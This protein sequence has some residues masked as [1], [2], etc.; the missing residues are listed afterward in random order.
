MDTQRTVTRYPWVVAT[1]AVGVVGLILAFALP[2]YVLFQLGGVEVTLVQALVSTFALIVAA[3][4]FRDMVEDLR[5]GAWGIDILAIVAICATVLVGEYWAALVVCLMLSGGEALEDFASA[6]ARSELTGVL[7]RAP[8]LAHRVD[9]DTVTTIPVTEVRVGD[10]LLIRPSEILPVDAELMTER[11]ALDESS[12]TGESLPVTHT[13]GDEVMSGSLNG[14]SAI[15]VRA[16]S[17][18]ANSRYQ[19]IVSLVAEA[20][21]SRSPMVRLADRIALPFTLFSLA[22]AGLGWYLAGDPLRAAQILVVATPCPLLIAAPVAFMAGMSR[23]ARAGIIVKDG[24]TIE[25]LSR[26]ETAAFDK[27]GTL[28]RGA[29]EVVDITVANGFSADEILQHAAAVEEYSTHPLARAIVAAAQTK[30]LSVPAASDV[31]EAVA[32]GFEGIVNGRKVAVGKQSWIADIVTDPS[33]IEGMRRGQKAGTSLVHVAIDGRYVGVIALADQ[34]RPEAA[35]TIAELG[36]LGVGRVMMLSG[37]TPATAKLVGKELGI[38]DVRAGLLP[39]DKVGAIND[40]S[41]KPV[42]MVGDGVNDAPVL[43]AAD[44]GVAMGLTGSAAAADSADVVLMKDDVHR[45][46]V[47]VGVGQHTTRVAL[48]AIGIGVALSVILM[49]IAFTGV[50]PAIVG[51]GA[52]ELVDLVCILWA[53]RAMKPGRHEPALTENLDVRKEC[54]ATCTLPARDAKECCLATP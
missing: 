54:F 42:M 23:A 45:A 34:Y 7:E 24:G 32:A 39:E 33:A 37:D 47:A 1:L 31:T 49:G 53:L 12:L 44:V 11:A 36:R 3:D 38:D 6:R 28:T 30:G 5:R 29:P 52:Q 13:R 22:V 27:T 8:S 2:R 48:Q 15:H 4:Q 46:A 51:A 21:E 14:S 17:D 10:I 40:A 9:G 20:A 43:A 25:R 26:I 19:Q 16:L 18:A 41:I 50:M 35:R